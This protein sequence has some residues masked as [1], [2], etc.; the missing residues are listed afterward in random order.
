MISSWMAVNN[1]AQAAAL[2]QTRG[3]EVWVA[4]ED[5]QRF[6]LG[7]HYYCARVAGEPLETNL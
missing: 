4:R 3:D 1:V 7:N 6:T 2:Q 5:T